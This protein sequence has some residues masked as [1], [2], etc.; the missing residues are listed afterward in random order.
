VPPDRLRYIDTEELR[1]YLVDPDLEMTFERIKETEPRRAAEIAYALGEMRKRSGDY[2][3][4]K[5]YRWESVR[6]FLQV[7]VE[8]EDDAEA[9]YCRINNVWMPSLMHEGVVLNRLRDT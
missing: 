7:R 2:E 5:W 8:T 6:L 9:L 4:M 3:L 1:M